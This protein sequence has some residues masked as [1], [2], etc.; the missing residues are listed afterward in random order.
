MFSAEGGIFDILNAETINLLCGL[1]NYCKNMTSYCN[2]SH[3]VKFLI[4]LFQAR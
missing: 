3:S 2:N 4:D 1:S